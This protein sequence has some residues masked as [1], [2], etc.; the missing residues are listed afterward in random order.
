MCWPNFVPSMNGFAK[1]GFFPVTITTLI[2][3]VS[4]VVWKSW[5][6]AYPMSSM[7]NKYLFYITMF[8]ETQT[9]TLKFSLLSRVQRLSLVFCDRYN[10]FL[11]CILPTTLFSENGEPHLWD[12]I[13]DINKISHN[14]QLFPTRDL[15]FRCEP[16]F[17]QIVSSFLKI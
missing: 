17:S 13:S 8:Q 10:Q 2:W 12:V 6:L 5:G 16:N 15:A 4:W 7:H 1:A 3:N 11:I 9:H 14:T